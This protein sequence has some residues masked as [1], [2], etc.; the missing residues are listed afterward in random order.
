MES[1]VVYIIEHNSG[2][3]SRFHVRTGASWCLKVPLVNLIE[4]TLS[5]VKFC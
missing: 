5:V 2:A 3:Q 1:V 4:N